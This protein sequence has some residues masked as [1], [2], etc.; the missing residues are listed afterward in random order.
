MR[1]FGGCVFCITPSDYHCG[2]RDPG[3]GLLGGGS[4]LS[5]G[6]KDTLE[7]FVVRR[8]HV[9]RGFLLLL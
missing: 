8:L 6:E 3:L 9:W 7:V 1:R 2:T 5:F 4:G